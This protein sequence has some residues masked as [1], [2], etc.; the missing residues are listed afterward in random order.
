MNTD[1]YKQQA[2]NAALDLIHSGM[3]L[4]L[5]TGSTAT[6]LLYGIARGLHDGRLRNIVGVP[7]SERT[8]QLALHLGIPLTNLADHPVLDLALD[9]ADE[10]DPALGL[11]KGMGG[12]LLREKIVAAAASCF[13]VMADASK[14]VPQL[15]YRTPVPV[16]VVP[17]AAPLCS[18]HLAALGATVVVR[19]GEEGAPFRT[20]EGHI[21]LDSSFGLIADP[22]VLARAI[23]DI[24]GVVEHGL[25]LSMAS[26]AVIAG[27]DGVRT[28][29]P[30]DRT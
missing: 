16:E 24:P 18:R 14:C 8:A 6:Y 11:I 21:I 17:F 23:R 10:I 27:P 30:E 3:T 1:I 29:T 4:G 20:D 7:T 22:P 9:G 28:I 26:L 15:G 25:F 12:A 2:A 13:V 19:R 5:G